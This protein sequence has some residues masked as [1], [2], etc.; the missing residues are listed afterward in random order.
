MPPPAR[1]ALG[2]EMTARRLSIFLEVRLST[3]PLTQNEPAW[4]KERREKQV[5]LT[6]F[7]TAFS[8]RSFLWKLLFEI[9]M[10]IDPPRRPR[11]LR[12]A[13]Y[14]FA[15]LLTYIVSLLLAYRSSV[16]IAQ[17][18]AVISPRHPQG[19]N[20]P[21]STARPDEKTLDRVDH[22]QPEKT[23]LWNFSDQTE[24]SLQPSP[25]IV[26]LMSFGGSVRRQTTKLS[27]LSSHL[28]HN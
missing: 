5:R 23:N 9:T 26:W 27:C 22:E 3:V 14:L 28:S 12:N 17:Q 6:I 15:A 10:S 11:Y 4:E 19:N 16:P 2:Q 18:H 25:G 24:I 8:F 21:F 20:V 1:N 7:W 13:F